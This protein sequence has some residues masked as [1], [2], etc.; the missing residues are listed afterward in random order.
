MPRVENGFGGGGGGRELLGDS[1]M[2]LSSLCLPSSGGSGGTGGGVAFICLDGVCCSCLATT[3]G[4]LE[5]MSC[6]IENNS[7]RVEIYES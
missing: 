4:S 3:G 7:D 5:K 6:S 2:A 1:G